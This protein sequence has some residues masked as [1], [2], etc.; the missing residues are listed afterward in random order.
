M[1]TI[2]L[3]LLFL[4]V[5]TL[6]LFAQHETDNWYF[7]DKAG[8]SFRNGSPEPLTDGQLSATN[9]SAVMSDKT[10]GKLLFYTDGSTIWNAN[11]AIVKNGTDLM[12]GKGGSQ[13]ALIVPN[14]A[15]CMEYYIFTVPDLN[16]NHTPITNNMH[17]SLI[18]VE[19]PDCEV[20]FKNKVLVN[21]ISGV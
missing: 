9:A 18:S 14:P 20:I 21:S 7:G 19:N 15:N 12:G 3:L 4:S 17:Y 1:K 5:N 11:H 6:A 13:S 8:L 2:L 10:T 16:P